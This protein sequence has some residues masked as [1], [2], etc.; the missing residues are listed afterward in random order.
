M[1]YIKKF[2]VEFTDEKYGFEIRQLQGS[3]A[4]IFSGHKS[5]SNI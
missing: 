4:K 1:I 5:G 3:L 2:Y